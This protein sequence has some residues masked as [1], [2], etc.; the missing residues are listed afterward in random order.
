M[1][2]V[3]SS[4]VSSCLQSALKA[5]QSALQCNLFGMKDFSTETAS[6]MVMRIGEW[7]LPMKSSRTVQVHFR[8]R[9]A[10]AIVR[11]RLTDRT[12]C[13]AEVRRGTS[14]ESDV[15]VSLHVVLQV[16]PSCVGGRTPKEST[17]GFEISQDNCRT[18][19]KGT[20]VDFRLQWL[21]RW[22]IDVNDGELGLESVDRDGDQFQDVGGGDDGV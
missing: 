13:V 10:E 16:A 21:R 11:S 7:S 9:G 18:V 19:F 20:R 4:M 1:S 12:G 3:T 2:S 8:A 5:V 15:G 6:S 14:L 17:V 22:M